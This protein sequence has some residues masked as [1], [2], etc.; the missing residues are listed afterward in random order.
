MKKILLLLLIAFT[1][2]SCEKDDICDATTPTTP[3]LIVQFY[4]FSNPTTLKS[5]TNL[6][7]IA[8][9]FTNGIGFTG[10]SKIQVPLKTTED[11]TTFSFI[12]N[13]SDTNTTNDN[14]DVIQI[15]YTRENVFVSR[16]CGYKTVFN[17]NSPNGFVQTDNPTPDGLWIQDIDIITTNIATENEIHVKLYF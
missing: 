1:F 6:G 14:I 13:G 15:S 4:D 2:S 3:R 10:V 12:Q 7:I 17:L 8:P 16:A 5:V 9:G 11:T